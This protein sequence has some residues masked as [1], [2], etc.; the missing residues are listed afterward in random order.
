[1]TEGRI[2]TR[3]V[4]RRTTTIHLEW[5]GLE[6]LLKKFAIDRLE[7]EGLLAPGA[8]RSIKIEIKQV[9]S[10]SPTYTEDKWNARFDID[11]DLKNVMPEVPDEA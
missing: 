8:E 5:L 11:Q 2:V 7:E 1:M 9:K 4:H 3:D 6:Q 10:G